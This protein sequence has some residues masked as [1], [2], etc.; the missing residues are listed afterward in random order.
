MPAVEE[1]WHAWAAALA[2]LC[3]GVRA[4]RRRGWLL[5][6]LGIALAG[7]CAV[8]RAAAALPGRPASTERRLRRWLAN[9]AVE[10]AALW[11]PVLAGL[12][13]RWAGREVTLVFDPTPYRGS[14]TLLVVGVV[15][16]ERALPVA[17]AA[18]PQ[19]ERWPEALAPA[20]G[21]LLGRV[22]AALPTGA[23][24]VTV[25]LDRGLQ[26]AAVVD[27]VAARGWHPVLRL[28]AGAGEAAR[29]RLA[30]GAERRLAA[31]VAAVA[32]A[33]GAFWAGPARLCKGA[34]WRAGCLTVWGEAGQAEPLVLCSTRPG[35]LARAREYG[36]RMAAEAACQ[37]LTARGLGL[38]GGRLRS[39][40][41]PERLLLGAV[42]ALWLLRLLRLLGQ[43]AVRHG[44]P[45]GTRTAATWRRRLARPAR[46]RPRPAPLP[47]G[48]R[49][50]RPSP[51][52][53][54][55][56]KLS[57]CEREVGETG[58]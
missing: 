38:E 31:H 21:R 48:P 1:V 4:T 57:C 34:G 43:R 27:A 41:A 42:L 9:A 58:D 51:P 52:L 30:D 28:R 18:V 53:A 8:G 16:G 7:S 50:R 26:G 5:L 2:E 29:V 25:L 23:G 45:V 44:W 13:A 12:L 54:A 35:G 39:A 22:A 32:P 46:P 19:Q 56:T 47:L 17:W 14:H 15:W 20:L 3:P 10:P 33:A 11:G 55:L 37:D 24:P 36:R 6:A 49:L 40:A